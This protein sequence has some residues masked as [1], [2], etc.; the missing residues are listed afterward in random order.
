[1]E[2]LAERLADT[3]AVI[4][5]AVRLYPP[6]AAVSRAAV[7]ADELSGCRI[8]S[9][10]VIA[11]D[12]LHRHRLLWERPDEFDP[13]R[14]PARAQID[15]FTYLPFGVAPRICI[16]SGFALREATLVVATVM[17]HFRL[18]PVPGRRVS[19]VLKVT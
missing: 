14:F 1:V 12:V 9:G 19:P 11:P 4:E 8:K 7:A 17:K 15:R 2:G 13:N 5:E 10:A 16:G 6:L 18:E 3:R